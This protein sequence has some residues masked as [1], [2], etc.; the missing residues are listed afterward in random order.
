MG[1]YHPEQPARLQAVE[2]QL[3]ASGLANCLQYVEA[4]LAERRHLERVHTPDYIDEIEAAAPEKGIIHLDPDTAMNPHTLKAALRAAGAAVL[5]TDMVIKGEADSAFCSVR[6]PGHHA[7]RR[8]A[9]GFCLFNNIAVAAAHALDQHGLDCVAIVDFDVH[10]G[11]G[12][13]D[14]FRDDPRVLMVSTFQHPFYPYSGI[15]GRSERM[16]NIPLA[17]YSAGREF[18]AAVE[19]YWLPALAAFKPRMLFIS[20]GFD[21]HR[22]DE[23]AMLNLVEAD[24][25]WV[26]RELRQVADKHS[27]GRI[28]SVLEGGYELGALGRC[29]MTHL[30]ILAN[31]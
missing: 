22:D 13:E 6:P 12:T 20:A 18:R 24:Y 3:I 21:A 19:Q 1:G 28:V 14:I 8:R 23:L 2:D 4:P 30:K 7:E 5:A 17:A 10:H 31:L 25:A 29:V 15:E 9:M 27:N 11:N 16:V 26:T